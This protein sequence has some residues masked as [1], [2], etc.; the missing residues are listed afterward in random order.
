MLTALKGDDERVIAA[1]GSSTAQALLDPGRVTAIRPLRRCLEAVAPPATIS[2]PH[3]LSL[4]VQRG[5][6]RPH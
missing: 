5:T 6:A 4:L 1:A 2:V 3:A